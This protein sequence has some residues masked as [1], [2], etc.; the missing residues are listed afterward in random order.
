MK[1]NIA[2]LFISALAGFA[3]NPINTPTNTP[4]K[5]EDVVTKM[6]RQDTIRQKTSGAYSWMARYSLHNRSRNAE[7]L[8]HWTRTADG[9][10][11]YE[12]ISES[13]DGGVRDHVFH[14]LLES[15]VEASKPSER[16]R[17][18]MDFYNY[19]FEYVDQE[20]LDGR[21][22]FVF[23][24]TPRNDSKYLTKG[25][26]WIDATDFAVI[27]V[28]GAPAHNPS[29]WT[30]KVDFVQRYKKEG[31]VWVTASNHSITEAKIFGTAD[32]TIEYF[33][34]NIAPV[35]RAESADSR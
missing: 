32:L 13:G 28:T 35:A 20:E 12:I 34:Y 4:V 30:K 29:F 23:D 15:E 14:K 26:V 2:I 18:R 21:P 31:D 6:M 22:A 16:N 8:V 33:D 17:S 1:K 7:M 27:Q 10:K 24:L 11:R 9:L 25:R 5:P 19:S 3:G